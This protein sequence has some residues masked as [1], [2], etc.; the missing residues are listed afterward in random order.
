MLF[1]HF[2][3]GEQLF[4]HLVIKRRLGSAFGIGKTRVNQHFF[5]I[6]RFELCFCL[7][8]LRFNAFNRRAELFLP[9]GL[10]VNRLLQLVNHSFAA[11]AH[12]EDKFLEQP[13]KHIY[14]D[15]VRCA[16]LESSLVVC[17]A[18]VGGRE[19]GAGH[20]EHRAAAVAAEHKAG[21]IG[22]ILLFTTII[23]I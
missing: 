13:V 2:N 8:Q 20:R 9:L 5:F 15:M 10:L 18:G 14:A 7:T 6:Q 3:A 21:I 17:T 1:E 11:I 23:A 19:V 22:G 12:A 16:A 4:L